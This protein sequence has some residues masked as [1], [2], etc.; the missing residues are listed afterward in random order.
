LNTSPC[1]DAAPKPVLAQRH[2]PEWSVEHR[3]V[4]D[5]GGA[6]RREVAAL[7]EVRPFAV[8]DS[9]DQLGNQEVQVRVALP[10]AMRRHVDRHAVDEGREVRAVIEIEATQEVLVGLAV[11][12][13][14]RDDHPRHELEDLTGAKGRTALQQLGADHAL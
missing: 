3:P 5:I 7:R 8:L 4:G 14:L 12:A 2:G 13:V 9:I 1:G 11:A 10:V 6:G